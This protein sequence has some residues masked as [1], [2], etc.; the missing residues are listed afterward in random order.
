MKRSEINQIIR[1]GEDFF[2]Q[3]S[4]YLPE[5]ASWDWDTWQR[6]DKEEIHEILHQEL[7]WDITDFG[8]G[9]FRKKGLLLFTVRNGATAEAGYEKPYCE[10]IMIVDDGQVCLQHF[11]WDKVEDIINRGGGTLLLQFY[12]ATA[13]EDLDRENPVIVYVDGI[14]RLLPAGGILALNPGQSVTLP[15]KLYHSFWGEGKVLVGE[16]S[17]INDDHTDNRF[18]EAIPRF[19]EIEEDEPIT[20]PL[21]KDTIRLR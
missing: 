13:E 1:D 11:H 15:Q 14:K 17:K 4:F 5:W 12:N 7:G 19:P 2:R 21:T 3:N 16:V 18:Y 8:L 20:Y 6:K 10:K 9:D